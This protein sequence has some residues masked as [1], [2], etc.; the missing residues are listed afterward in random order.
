V[1]SEEH[2]SEKDESES[3][4]SVS[5]PSSKRPH[6]PKKVSSTTNANTSKRQ[7]DHV[8]EKE[9]PHF[10][11]DGV[12]VSKADFEAFLRH[13]NK[14][15]HHS[16]QVDEEVGRSE[17]EK[18]EADQ[19]DPKWEMEIDLG[20]LEESEDEEDLEELKDRA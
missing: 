5:E 18:D 3:D 13:Q 7:R 20:E 1:V 15:G 11:Y 9:T 10:V 2:D 8:S 4:E 12:R 6:P 17:G 16:D 14:T 19:E